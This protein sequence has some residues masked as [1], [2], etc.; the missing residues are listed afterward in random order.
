MELQLQVLANCN[1]GLEISKSIFKLQTDFANFLANFRRNFGGRGHY[2]KS[3]SR[4]TRKNT[5]F[6]W[7]IWSLLGNIWNAFLVSIDSESMKI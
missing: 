7:S 4:L 6:Q 1:L 5:N 3:T 2:T